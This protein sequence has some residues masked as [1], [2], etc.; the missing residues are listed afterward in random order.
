M[1]NQNKEMSKIKKDI[2]GFLSEWNDEDLS[3]LASNNNQLK[4]QLFDKN[5][6]PKLKIWLI[7]LVTLA[8]LILLVIVGMLIYLLIGLFF[9]I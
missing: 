6:S 4:S 5:A 9:Y 8:M 1:N 3:R 7:I 2:L